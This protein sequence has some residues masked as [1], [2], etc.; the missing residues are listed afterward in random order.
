MSAPAFANRNVE[1]NH[2][3]AGLAAQQQAMNSGGPPRVH[4]SGSANGMSQSQS[5]Q[6][7]AG[8]LRPANG[9][10]ADSYANMKWQQDRQ[11]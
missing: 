2:G 3:S 9:I 6:T 1:M 10:A 11:Q 4:Y 5:E 7:M 8:M